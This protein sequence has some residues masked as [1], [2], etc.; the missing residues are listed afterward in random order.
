MGSVSLQS[1][2]IGRAFALGLT[3][4]VAGVALATAALVAHAQQ[5]PAEGRD[6]TRIEPAQAVDVPGKIEVIEF[7][8]YWCP[9][10]NEFD[11]QLNDWV[12]KQGPDV[13]VRHVPIAFYDSQVPLQRIYYVL[14]ALGKESALRAKVFSAIHV[15]HNPLATAEQQADWAQH[16]GIDRAK[17]LE[18]Y[19]S[20]SIQTKARRA[21]QL[22]EAYGVSAVPTIVIDGKYSLGGA[23]NTTAVM[24]YLVAEDR[25]T[26]K[27]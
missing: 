22:M 16:N 17:Y 24:D 19:N 21:S 5:P 8:G 14:E 4:A 9:H 10:C 15:E 6:Y 26:Q 3:R 23:P 27:K 2:S 7:F 13:V 18:L 20:F 25:K 11:P 1:N 12:R